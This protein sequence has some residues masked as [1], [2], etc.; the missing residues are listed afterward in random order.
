MSLLETVEA[1]A[2]LLVAGRSVQAIEQYYAEDV[3]VFENRELVRAGLGQC[4]QFEQRSLASLEAPPRIKLTALAVNQQTAVSFL[5]YTLRFTD[6][7]GRHLRLEQVAVQRWER[8]RI[9]QERFYYEGFVDEGEE[10]S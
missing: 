9:A 3:C 1:Y 10:R 7:E 2:A 5:E 4:V 8:N 6:A